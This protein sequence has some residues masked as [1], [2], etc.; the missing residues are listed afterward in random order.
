MRRIVTLAALSVL[1]VPMPV[2]A[3]DAGAD[4]RAAEQLADTLRNP[5]VQDQMA[6]VVAA[7]SEA[8]LDMDLSPMAEAVAKAT[9]EELPEMERGRTLREMSPDAERLPETIDRELPRAM[10]R[11]ADMGDAFALMLPALREM[12][13]QMGR[14]VEKS[15]DPAR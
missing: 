9:G 12:A 3:Q 15:V 4:E 14:A 1:A 11:M 8:L 6:G 5:V 13:E 7:M 10:D 2:M